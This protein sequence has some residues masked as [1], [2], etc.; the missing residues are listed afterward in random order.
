MRAHILPLYHILGRSIAVSNM[1][2]L[3]GMGAGLIL[4][5]CVGMAVA[6]DKKTGKR[7]FGKAV[8]ALGQMIEDVS[9]AIGF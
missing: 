3:K 6:P 8:K 9:C 7:R 2:F 1:N 5:A 4:G